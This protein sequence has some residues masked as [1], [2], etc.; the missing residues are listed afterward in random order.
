MRN[1]FG[2]YI[3]Y[4]A[5]DLHF[6]EKVGAGLFKNISI[7]EA[8][9]E[10]DAIATDVDSDDSGAIY[11]YSFPTLRKD[12]DKFPIKIGLTLGN[13]PENRVDLQCRQTCCFEYPVILGKW[14]MQR[15][16]SVES[17]IHSTL[18]ARGSKR[19]AP[20][21]EWFDTTVAE[22]ESII[23]FVQPAGQTL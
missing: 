4:L 14:H 22:I 15:V 11:A 20:G 2:F 7:D 9:A 18:E 5:E 1:I 16:A 19:D 13:D 21:K 10:A 8:I 3:P 23:K 17:A 6:F 12:G